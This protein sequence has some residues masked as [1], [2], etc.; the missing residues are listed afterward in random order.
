MCSRDLNAGLFRRKRRW[1]SYEYSTYFAS[2]AH[3][4]FITAHSVYHFAL[5]MSCLILW[6]GGFSCVLTMVDSLAMKYREAWSMCSFLSSVPTFLDDMPSTSSTQK[7]LP[8]KSFVKKLALSCTQDFSSFCFLLVFHSNSLSFAVSEIL[9][10][11]LFDVLDDD[12]QVEIS[13]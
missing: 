2:T 9:T 6:L 11:A 4:L 5:K 13:A 10:Q 3:F 1:L 7:H 8:F 12:G